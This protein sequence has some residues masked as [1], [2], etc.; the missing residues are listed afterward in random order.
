MVVCPMAPRKRSRQFFLVSAPLLALFACSSS[1]PTPKKTPYPETKPDAPRMPGKNTDDIAPSKRPSSGPA[2]TPQPEF[3]GEDDLISRD[4]LTFA[5]P[6]Q[7]DAYD[8]LEACFVRYGEDW[9]AYPRRR[10]GNFVNIEW[11]RGE[12][13]HINCAGGNT[14]KVPGAGWTSLEV[15]HHERSWPQVFGLSF[16]LGEIPK[17]EGIAV[18][19]SW[20]QGGQSIIG[21]HISATFQEVQEGRIHSK[22]SLGMAQ[23]FILGETQIESPTKGTAAQ[24]Y[25][26]L[27]ASPES[28]RAEATTQL[29]GLQEAVE[30]ALASDTPRKCVYGEYQGGGISPK[31]VKKVPLDA[32]EKAEARA[33]LEQ[34]LA[35]QRNLITEHADAMHAR[36]VA[37][38][39]AKCWTPAATQTN[40]E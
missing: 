5:T 20:T 21:D 39:P 1:T 27:I 35:P 31:C 25:K 3:V 26:R 16:T 23:G 36:L 24:L 40:S 17:Q 33:L 30:R 29:D 14:R 10:F 18:A 19:F 2:R 9:T 34:I 15:L 22:L 4:Q 6:E 32:S 37:L 11:C 28:L 7:A 13:S 38:L 12:G 8:A